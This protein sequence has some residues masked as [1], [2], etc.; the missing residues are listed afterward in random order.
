MK[1]Y[2]NKVTEIITVENLVNKNLDMYD[3]VSQKGDSFLEVRNT[4]SK[5]VNN[6]YYMIAVKGDPIVVA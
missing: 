4:S 6:S 1:I 2:A 5:F 3:F